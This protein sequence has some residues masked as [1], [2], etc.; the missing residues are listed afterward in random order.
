MSETQEG[1]D[2][3]LCI[4]QDGLNDHLVS[5]EICMSLGDNCEIAKM[6][7]VELRDVEARNRHLL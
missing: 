5:C 1:P 6:L 4:I 3:A 7:D 2:P